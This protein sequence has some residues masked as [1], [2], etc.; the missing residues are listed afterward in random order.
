MDLKSRIAKKYMYYSGLNC[1][2]LNEVS[3]FLVDQYKFEDEQSLLAALSSEPVVNV[4]DSFSALK[5]M[6]KIDSNEFLQKERFFSTPN[7]FTEEDVRRIYTEVKREFSSIGLSLSE[8]PD[9]HLVENYPHPY[10]NVKGVALAPDETDRKRYGIPYAILIRRGSVDP[11]ILPVLIA[12]ELVHFFVKDQG[13]L[14]RGLE[15]GFADFLAFFVVGPRVM[16]ELPLKRYFLSKRISPRYSSPR[17]RTYLDYIRMALGIYTFEGLER[18]VEIILGGRKEIKKIE[19]SVLNEGRVFTLSDSMQHASVSQSVLVNAWALINDSPIFENLSA[20]S[21]F[22][23]TSIFD[24]RFKSAFSGSV[25]ECQE[26]IEKLLFGCV[27]SD[28]GNLEF[29]DFETLYKS[30]AVRF[31]VGKLA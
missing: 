24:E 3:E 28:D 20:I 7:E 4:T 11:T 25:R 15:E 10:E 19:L 30:R 2:D 6:L 16:D 17:F 18:I 27:V 13:L 22:Y 31:S 14:A 12:H 26:E 9:I 29:E 1:L 8:Y 21:Y 23:M 5:F